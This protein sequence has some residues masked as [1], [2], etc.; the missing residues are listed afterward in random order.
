MGFDIRTLTMEEWLECMHQAT[1]RATAQINDFQNGDS[2]ASNS[3]GGKSSLKIRSKEERKEHAL[4]GTVAEYIASKYTKS[5]WK[6]EMGQYKGNSN[7]DLTVI[8]R[9]KS[10]NCEVRGTNSK[11][12]VIYRPHHDNSRP[13]Y[14]YVV[15]TN[16]YMSLIGIQTHP[17]CSVGYSFL[18][19]LQKLID[20]H[21][22]WIGKHPGNIYYQIPFKYFSEDFSNF[23]N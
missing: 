23:G 17:I 2:R 11:D 22:E 19:D 21:P 12:T 20:N 18:G 3:Y 10:V 16:L 15:V 1:Q 14:L 6:K 5:I 7:P 4:M 8:F 13:D 9:G